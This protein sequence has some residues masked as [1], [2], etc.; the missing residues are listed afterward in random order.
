LG[1]LENSGVGRGFSVEMKQREHVKTIMISEGRGDNVLFE[2]NLGQFLERSMADDSV[3]EVRGV[4]GILR[5]DLTL[6]ELDCMVSKIRQDV[7]HVAKTE[8]M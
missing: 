6:D 7:L 2:G 4:N 1:R 8:M 3:L 5:M